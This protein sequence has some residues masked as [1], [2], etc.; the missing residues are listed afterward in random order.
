MGDR[1]ARARP[2]G[3]AGRSGGGRGARRPTRSCR[4]TRGGG[5]PQRPGV[6]A[7]AAHRQGGDGAERAGDEVAAVHEVYRPAS[8]TPIASWCAT[9]P[10]SG[11]QR[12]SVIA[13]G[14]RSQAAG[15]PGRSSSATAWATLGTVAATV[16]A[17][18]RLIVRCRW[19][20]TM[21]STLRVA[22]DD[23]RQLPAAQVVE[24][25]A[26]HVAD[27][28]GERRVVDGHDGRLVGCARQLDLEPV[29]LAAG[30][31][32][33]R[34]AGHERIERQEAHRAVDG[35][36]DGR[37]PAQVAVPGEGGPQPLAVVVVAG[38]ESQR[39][40][41]RRHRRG[42]L[43]VLVDGARVD[44]VAGGQHDVGLRVEAVELLDRGGEEGQRVDRTAGAAHRA[45][46]RAGR[47][48]ERTARSRRP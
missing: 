38:Q 7:G 2:G 45:R 42:E 6:R 16:P 24:G 19:P 4:I 22:G 17:K 20:Q 36:V 28:R 26:V 15:P 37:S 47:R 14:S 43:G 32:P 34:G 39:G 46:P 31:V 41:E 23:L 3:P 25:H 44:Q 5:L 33:A 10:S 35:V 48:C 30:Q 18:R 1:A 40:P 21:R 11:R 8:N 27:A 9:R 29:Q 12:Y 13:G